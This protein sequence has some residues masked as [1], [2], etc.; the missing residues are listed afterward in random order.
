MN[1]TPAV[2]RRKTSIARIRLYG[3]PSVPNTEKIQLTVNG[4]SAE[5][6]FSGDTAKALYRQPFI[7]T[8]TLNKYSAS[9]MVKGG[10]KNSQLGATVHGLSRALSALDPTAFRP[11]LKSAG[12]LTRDPRARQRRQVGKGGKSRRGKQSPKR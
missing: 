4:V 12:L 11:I 9:I 3:K 2:G 10:G 6:Y 5:V 1:Y 7:L 8:D